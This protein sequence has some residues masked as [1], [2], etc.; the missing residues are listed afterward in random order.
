M[1]KHFGL[2]PEK[3]S[4][5]S[6]SVQHARIHFLRLI[7]ELKRRT[8][9]DILAAHKPFSELLSNSQN[10]IDSMYELEASKWPEDDV[11]MREPNGIRER[12]V[13]NFIPSWTSLQKIEGASVLCQSLQDW[14]QT[15]NLTDD[16]CLD[17][18]IA[19]LRAFH[20]GAAKIN[21]QGLLPDIEVFGFY[22]WDVIAKAWEKALSERQSQ[23]AIT[24]YRTN[25][26]FEKRAPRL[27]SFN[28]EFE[29]L[30]LHLSGPRWRREREFREEVKK[31]FDEFGGR[32]IRGAR[33]ALDIKIADYI[34]QVSQVE[35]ELELI[36]PPTL[37][38]EDHFKW[39]VE[40]Q[41]PPTKEYRK[42]AGEVKKAE[43]TI[44]EGVD[45]VAATLGLTQRSTEPDKHPGRPKGSKNKS[46]GS[47]GRTAFKGK[48]VQ[49]RNNARI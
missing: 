45:K 40:H 4:P 7:L 19:F 26:E 3:E 49:K 29:S 8:A 21:W 23:A 43:S 1:A 32:A 30:K 20:F 36:P 10:K 28:F 15:Y 24:H 33:K 18:A 12:A 41:I 39:L 16:W 37:W 35:N 46:E 27:Y 31:K 14:A 42:I 25:A 47:G 38:A 6:P 48:K 11:I 13:R 22:F 34:R 17:H 5:N 2:G 44:R 9:L